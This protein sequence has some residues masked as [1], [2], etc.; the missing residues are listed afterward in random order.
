MRPGAADKKIEIREKLKDKNYWMNYTLHQRLQV[1]HQVDAGDIKH[2]VH[3]DDLLAPGIG[4]A[5]VGS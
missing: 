2:V 3:D 5:R 4:E 1:A